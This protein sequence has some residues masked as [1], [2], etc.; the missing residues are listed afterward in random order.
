MKDSMWLAY[1]QHGECYERL[2][3][4]PQQP[5]W[6]RYARLNVARLQPV[7]GMLRETRL[8][9]AARKCDLSQILC[10]VVP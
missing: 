8:L 5:A 10:S 6:E 1:S 2:N 3:M 7:W 4:A 9:P